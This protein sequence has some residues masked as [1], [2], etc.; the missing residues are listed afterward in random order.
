LICC[1][2]L[3]AAIVVATTDKPA[4]I[5]FLIANAEPAIGPNSKIAL[6]LAAAVFAMIRA[7]DAA[8]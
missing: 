3:T 7:I 5:L 4:E 1:I 6:A 2:A 8:D